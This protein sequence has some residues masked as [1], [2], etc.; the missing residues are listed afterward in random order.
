MYGVGAEDKTY[1][2]LQFERETGLGSGFWNLNALL[3]DTSFNK[4]IPPNPSN[5]FK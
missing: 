4:I 1:I 3:L 5:L 2:L